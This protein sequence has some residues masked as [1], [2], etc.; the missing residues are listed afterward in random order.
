LD[1]DPRPFDRLVDIALNLAKLSL[2]SVCSFCTLPSG[3][4]DGVLLGVDRCGK[5]DKAYDRDSTK[6]EKRSS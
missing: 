2:S 1:E 4:N 3:A 5:I 6:D